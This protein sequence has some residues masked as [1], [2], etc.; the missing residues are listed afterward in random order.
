[1]RVAYAF[2]SNYA[3]PA[4]VSLYSLLE[5]T[6]GIDE[7]LICHDSES[8]AYVPV[9]AK[10]LNEKGVDFR[11][12]AVTAHGSSSQQGHVS[13]MTFAKFAIWE[14][15]DDE[16]TLYIDS[17][18]L[19]VGSLDDAEFDGQQ[20]LAM[21]PHGHQ[22]PPF[23][24]TIDFVSD[25]FRFNAGVILFREK[26][27]VDLQS[28]IDRWSPLIW[29]DQDLFNLEFADQID[30]LPPSLNVNGFS[31]SV[32]QSFLRPKIFHYMGGWKPWDVPD[33]WRW[34]CHFVSC[35]FSA[36]YEA[37]ARTLAW[38][39]KVLE[40]DPSLRRPMKPSASSD[41]LLSKLLVLSANLPWFQSLIKVQARIRRKSQF[42]PLH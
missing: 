42:H 30:I 6:N 2:D 15:I 4:L 38:L 23:S 13:G 33:G 5:T 36:W 8:G 25:R 11:A 26:L 27:A 31:Y 29:A 18:T 37:E 28:C 3:L 22:E 40:S 32:A 21:V 41:T 16:P 12:L 17:D 14:A 24:G 10:L 7:V 9:F 39:S 34:H 20:I 1:V 19:V 35:A